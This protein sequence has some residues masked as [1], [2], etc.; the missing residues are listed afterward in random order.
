MEKDDWPLM[1]R[2]QVAEGVAVEERFIQQFGKDVRAAEVGRPQ[3]EPVERRSENPR[4][5][6]VLPV[7]SEKALFEVIENAIAIKS[8]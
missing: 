2:N 3:A 8:V 1:A 5:Q 4:T 7:L 6:L